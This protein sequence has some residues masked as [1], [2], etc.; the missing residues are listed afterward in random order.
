MKERFPRIALI[1]SEV[2]KYLHRNLLRK[3][4]Q[5]AGDYKEN[6]GPNLDPSER[7]KV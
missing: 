1:V 6:N 2:E 5:S 3:S 7:E 4:P